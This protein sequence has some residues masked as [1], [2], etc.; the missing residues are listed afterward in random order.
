MLLTI[1]KVLI[2]KSVNIFSQIPNEMLVEVAAIVT[3]IEVKADE[4]IFK[5]GDIG[6]SM[7]IIV[8]G[9]VKIHDDE[10]I[11]ATLKSRSVFG[12]LAALD[13]EP[14]SASA[15]AVGD[16]ILFKLDQD[17]LYELMGEYVEVARGIIQVLCQR[18]RG[19]IKK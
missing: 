19:N 16:T 6:K 10:K 9:E 8:E 1:E 7:Y 18:L 5:K 4:N 12:E 3:E 11:I 2:L 14:R 15:T 13:T 17:S